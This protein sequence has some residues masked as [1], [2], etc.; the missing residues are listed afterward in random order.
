MVR[1]GCLDREKD[2]KTSIRIGRAKLRC[3][4]PATLSEGIKELEEI[5]YNTYGISPRLKIQAKVELAKA[6]AKYAGMAQEIKEKDP[7]L[8]RVY[9]AR[10]KRSL[11]IA[12]ELFAT[13]Y[14]Y[15]AGKLLEDL[16]KQ[17]KE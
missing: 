3:I 11:V 16:S 10:A 1:R 14:A 5:A 7:V 2:L 6:L 12:R 4:D 8:Y 15:K 13:E 9:M 17:I